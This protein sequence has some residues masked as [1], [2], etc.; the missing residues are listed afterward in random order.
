MTTVA[1]L[2]AGDTGAATAAALARLQ[3]VQRIVIIDTAA[4]AAAGKALDIQ[5]AGAIAGLDTGLM[6]TDDVSRVTGCAV[7]VVADRFG[8]PS[9]EWDA[10]EGLAFVG[11]LV[12]LLGEA[13][14]VFAGTKQTSLMAAASRELGIP[15]SRVSG[16]APEAVRSAAIS[17]VAMEARCSPREVS[18]TVLGAPPSGLVVPWSDASIGGYS[19]QR[20]LDQVQ[21]NRVEARVASLW[22]PGP[23][24]LGAAAARVAA[25]MIRSARESFAV[26]T[27]IDGEF[28]VRPTIGVLPV[29]LSRSGI[30]HVRIPSLETRD[31]IRVETALIR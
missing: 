19:L 27:P 6:G 25:G 9:L 26:L 12:P 5:Q 24:A 20:V 10:E 28:G 18:L 31:R 17:M 16:A 2:G 1:I 3:C 4:S 30:V 7:C 21:L 23:Y 11:R 13:P 14:L 8:H 22:P 29:M 15:R